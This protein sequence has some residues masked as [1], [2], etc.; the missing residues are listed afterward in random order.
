MFDITQ[1]RT[2]VIQPA[3]K[4][5]NFYTPEAEELLVATCA[6][7]SKGGT[8]VQ[9]M[10]DGPARGCYQMEIATHDSLWKHYLFPRVDLSMT[11]MRSCNF[12]TQPNADELSSNLK[13]ASQMARIFYLQFN[14]KLPIADDIEGIWAYY[15]KYWNTEKGAAQHDDFIKN[16]NVFIGKKVK[17]A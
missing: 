17:A 6:Q 2:L 1:F 5:I 7:E 15:K 16:Y 8:Y 3:L 4:A 13:Y 9:Q 14:E 12:R 11:L 10:G